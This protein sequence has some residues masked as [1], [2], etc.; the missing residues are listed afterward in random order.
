MDLPSHDV[1]SRPAEAALG[2]VGGGWGLFRCDCLLRERFRLIPVV[3]P[4]QMLHGQVIDFVTFFRCVISLDGLRAFILEL[5]REQPISIFIE[6]MGSVRFL[7][8][9]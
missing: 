7:Y 5:N 8:P 9:S 2:F 3:S 6:S 4:G 1:K